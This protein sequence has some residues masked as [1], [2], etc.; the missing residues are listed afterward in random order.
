MA[1]ALGVLSWLLPVLAV[2]CI[3]AAIALS[4]TR[5]ETAATV[6]RALMW[7]AGVVGVLFVVGSVVVH[8]LD[9][10]TL[11]GAVAQ[12]AWDV[13]V[14]PLRWGVLLLAAFGLAMMLACD[15]GSPQVLAR[16]AARVRTA[17]LHP[18]S[19]VGVL[20]RAGLAVAL[21]IAA[22]TDPVGVI[23]PRRGRRRGAP[24]PVRHHGDLPRRHGFSGTGRRRSRG[25]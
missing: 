17:V 12:A 22:I 9:D 14:R 1:S 11:G 15:S 21:G 16:H 24:R 10:D 25:D 8:L 6:G 3:V 20:I 19:K 5:W 18:A 23:E 13:M 4:R 2:V 7:A